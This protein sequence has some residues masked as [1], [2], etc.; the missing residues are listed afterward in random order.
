MEL[1]KLCQAGSHSCAS[2]RSSWS[3]SG[4]TGTAVEQHRLSSRDVDTCEHAEAKQVAVVS[5]G[6]LDQRQLVAAAAAVEAVAAAA[7]VEAVAAATAVAVA[8]AAVV[9]VAVGAVVADAAAAGA[10]AVVAVGAIAVGAV[11]AA[12]GAG[13]EA[14]AAAAA[15]AAAEVVVAAAVA[16]VAA[17]V[18]V[19]K[20]QLKAECR[21]SLLPAALLCSYPAPGRFHQAVHH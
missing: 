7:A 3:G 8:A 12:V 2:G 4:A 5:S 21:P 1:Y 10:V 20:C 13:S 14:A 17:S 18:V 11:V 9:L 16:V 15:V 19:T 6:A